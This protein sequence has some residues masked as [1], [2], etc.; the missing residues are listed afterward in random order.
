[1][2]LRAWLAD[3]L[4]GAASA[5]DD[6]VG[7]SPTTDS[8]P[9]QQRAGPEVVANQADRATSL[10]ET[11]PTYDL[12]FTVAS[13]AA[14]DDL[15]ADKYDETPEGVDRA[16]QIRETGPGVVP[17]GA[18]IRLGTGGVSADIAAY[19]G[20]VYRRQY[21]GEWREGDRPSLTIAI[22]TDGETLEFEPQLYVSPAFA[23][24]VSFERM[25][26]HLFAD[27]EGDSRLD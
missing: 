13:L 25:H 27:R 6:A 11:F 15:I 5:S 16:A 22:E 18:T 17:D 23:G 8:G 21:D 7:T 4:G 20:E 24:H 9:T 12:D 26:E 14:V 2:G 19:V 3:R 10:Q 1:M